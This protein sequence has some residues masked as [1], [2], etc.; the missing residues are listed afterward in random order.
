MNQLRRRQL[1]MTW[2]VLFILGA[3]NQV[4]GQ[5]ATGAIEGRVSD[6]QQLAL[7]Q[8]AVELQDAQGNTVRKM[9]GD[10]DGH[11]RLDSVSSGT[12]TLQFSHNGFETATKKPVTVTDGRTTVLDVILQP[13][14]VV[15]TIT[16]TAPE[17]DRLVAS[18]I[19]IPVIALPVTV[20]TVPLE[21]IEQQ[22]STDVVAAINNIPGANAGTQ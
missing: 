14:Q 9:I 12:Y 15:Q 13:Q 22:N 10:G 21:L 1:K 19:D 7:P 5:S 4:Q 11:F 16:V 17:N 3:G 2:L 6:S 20:S 8:T 18:K